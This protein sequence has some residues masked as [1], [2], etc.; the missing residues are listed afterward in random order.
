MIQPAVD[1]Y[2][3]GIVLWELVTRRLPWDDADRY[4]DAASIEAAILGHER[5]EYEDTHPHGLRMYAIAKACWMDD[6]RAR[7]SFVA[8]GKKVGSCLLKH[9]ATSARAVAIGT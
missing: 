7:L 1:V 4:P 2:A 6:P 5:P 9:C 8:V 3:F